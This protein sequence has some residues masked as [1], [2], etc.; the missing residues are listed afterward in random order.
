MVEQHQLLE[1]QAQQTVAV[2]VVVVGLAPA[3][4]LQEATAALA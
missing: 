4:L 1:Q 2:A 3:Y